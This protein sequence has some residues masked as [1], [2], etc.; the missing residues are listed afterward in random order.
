MQDVKNTHYILQECPEC[1]ERLTGVIEIGPDSRW[2][3]DCR[4]MYRKYRCLLKYVGPRD[5]DRECFPNRFCISCG[6]EWFHADGFLRRDRFD[7]HVFDGEEYAKF[8]EDTEFS[9]APYLLNG[10]KKRRR[11]LPALKDLWNSL[12]G[13]I[14]KIR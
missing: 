12:F 8:L 6:F 9:F 10:G 5:Y 2:L 3:K 14:I 13:R 1:G 4:R 11:L 7:R